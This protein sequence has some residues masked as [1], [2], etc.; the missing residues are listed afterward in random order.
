MSKAQRASNTKFNRPPRV[1]KFA[2]DTLDYDDGIDERMGDKIEDLDAFLLGP[3]Q[4]AEHTTTVNQE[5][6]LRL[7]MA[8]DDIFEL[9]KKLKQSQLKASKSDDYKLKFD[10][11]SQNLR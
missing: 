1:Q 8:Q 9:D 4:K 6:K 7:D 5:L 3:V 11:A 2:G 10:S